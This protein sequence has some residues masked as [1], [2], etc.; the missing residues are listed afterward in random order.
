MAHP[1]Q[2]DLKKRAEVL[3][4]GYYAAHVDCDMSKSTFT[5]RLDE[6]L[7]NGIHQGREFL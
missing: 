4:C 5:F 1:G 2:I 6:A 3:R 7:I